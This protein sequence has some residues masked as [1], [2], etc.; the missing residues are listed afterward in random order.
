MSKRGVS[1]VPSLFFSVFLCIILLAILTL[2]I[3]P[4]FADDIS[5]ITYGNSSNVVRGQDLE[6]LTCIDGA[7]T[8]GF[9]QLVCNDNFAAIP[10]TT[11]Q[12][13]SSCYYSSINLAN[14]NCN[15]YTAE[16]YFTKSGVDK[17]VT[18]I[19]S[20][21][22][23]LSAPTFVLNSQTWDGGWG[24]A[25]N[26][27]YAIWVLSRYGDVYRTQINDGMNWLKNNRRNE[28][29]CWVN[30]AGECSPSETIKALAYLKLAN[31][32]DGN[33][34]VSDGIAYVE[35]LQKYIS[36]TA[37]SATLYARNDNTNCNV[38]ADGTTIINNVLFNDTQQTTGAFTANYGT[39]INMTC[40]KDITLALTDS[41][42]I[43]KFR[44]TF[45]AGAV[46]HFD[47]GLIQITS[48]SS[49]YSQYQIVRIQQPCWSVLTT[50]WDT[51][52]AGL[53]TYA[54][55]LG[56]NPAQ[57]AD[58]NAWLQTTLQNHSVIGKFISTPD[59]TRDSAF[60]LMTVDRHNK[61]ILDWLIYSQNN[62][63]SFGSGPINQKIEDTAAAYLALQKVSFPQKDE[64]L[65]DAAH[66]MSIAYNGRSFDNVQVDG[67]LF[68]ILS[69]AAQPFLLAK[70]TAGVVVLKN[71]EPKTVSYQPIG[72][73]QIHNLQFQ[74]FTTDGVAID[75]LSISGPSEVAGNGTL[76]VTLQGKVSAAGNTSGYVSIKGIVDDEDS[77]RELRRIYYTIQSDP[78]FS[79]TPNQSTYNAYDGQF[80]YFFSVDAINV[81]VNCNVQLQS[82]NL[83]G[84]R[85]VHVTT[86]GIFAMPL[87]VRGVTTGKVQGSGSL[88][89]DKLG[90]Q[91]I[92]PF[93][94]DVLVHD[95]IP[96]SVSPSQITI[97][98]YVKTF[99]ITVKNLIDQP[100]D[101]SAGL[102][103]PSEIYLI[104]AFQSPIAP[105]D[106]VT[107][108]FS[109]TFLAQENISDTNT[110]EITAFGKTLEVPVTITISNGPSSRLAFIIW[111]TIIVTFIATAGYI[112]YN[113]K[114]YGPQFAQI[115]SKY[116]GAKMGGGSSLGGK[117][118]SSGGGI[119]SSFKKKDVSRATMMDIISI[120]QS[121]DKSEPEII[122][123]LESE[124]Y[125]RPLVEGLIE[126][127][128][129]VQQKVTSIKREDTVLGI[130]HG[131]DSEIDVMTKVLKDKGF[132]E[133]DIREALKELST[134]TDSKEKKLRAEAG[135]G[136][137]EK[138][139]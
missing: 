98:S 121:M 13:S 87:T 2:T 104:D 8:F 1:L 93:D 29:K 119:L 49:D 99:S 86:Q 24:G 112:A 124:G 123:K 30:A 133:N 79:M 18:K 45:D 100:M 12:I 134:D 84:P 117:A 71:D 10:V 92:V 90:T 137:N 110:I 130:I 11:T 5:L 131:L 4:V 31:I 61:D 36:N 102:L 106:S 64:V 120:M 80:D 66:W 105:K 19:I 82:D 34:I 101:V 51:C 3:T 76:S 57:Q 53:T 44:Y 136:D 95:S 115:Y 60:Y 15:E 116:T 126:E 97:T 33:R 129:N 78:V 38:T 118:G 135:L 9:S 63:G 81:P 62:D 70:D 27:A 108:Y 26:T 128:R 107:I 32:T 20:T 22:T 138:I 6:Y 43:E 25:A 47:D 14:I 50:Q 23:V 74:Q 41:R 72:A 83:A 125:A 69:L 35:S 132:S 58:A 48:D 94:I 127:L 91:V 40:D 96:F 114:D 113:W 21:N 54:L 17:K 77:A 73:Q 37:W 85:Q 42:G 59:S 139:T 16:S 67:S 65:A 52:D 122:A 56:I 46:S 103:S 88:V 55:S 89:C 111:F 68:Q 28:P 7:N 39:I 109:T 75:A